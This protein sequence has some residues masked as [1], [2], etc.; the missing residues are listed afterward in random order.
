MQR[1]ALVAGALLTSTVATMSTWAAAATAATACELVLIEHRSGRELARLALDPARPA[2]R[3]AFT[4]SVLGTPVEDHYEWRQHG[5]GLQAHLV[6]ERFEGEGYGL[7]NAAAPGETLVRDGPGWR[8]TLD[9]VVHPLVVPTVQGMR[10]SVAD[11]PALILS[12]LSPKSIAL[13][14]HACPT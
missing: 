9:R 6:L 11:R 14:A 3:L 4:H 13:Q 5:P 12:T 8:L 1:A 7:P 10:L 2:A